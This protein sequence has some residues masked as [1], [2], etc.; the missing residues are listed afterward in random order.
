MSRPWMKFFPSDWQA[1]PVLRS[2]SLTARGLWIEMLCIMHKADPTGFLRVN[3]AKV[4]D[5]TLAVLCG[6]D[7][8]S[9]RSA[10]AELDRFGVYSRLDDGTIYSRRIV[11]DAEKA[12]IDKQNGGRGG[13]PR[14]KG[15]VNPPDNPN[16]NGGDKAHIPYAIS[17]K[18]DPSQEEGFSGVGTG[19]DAA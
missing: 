1:D 14:L 11:R 10:L 3:G 9:L 2:C 7:A 19:R 18:K 17:H 12:A 13:N 8:R 6:T 15:G 4:D 5:A 16:D